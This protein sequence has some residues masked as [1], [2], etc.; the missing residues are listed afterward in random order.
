MGP[1]R[2]TSS[3]ERRR[4]DI[5]SVLRDIEAAQEEAARGFRPDLLAASAGAADRSSSVA[6]PTD[7]GT[8]GAADGGP[9]LAPESVRLDRDV[10]E[11]LL[12]G[13]LGILM[14]W[15]GDAGHNEAIGRMHLSEEQPALFLA[16]AIRGGGALHE[17]AK[18]HDIDGDIFALAVRYAL[19]PFLGACARE[20]K[21]GGRFDP[22]SLGVGPAGGRCPVCGAAPFMA[23]LEEEDGRKRLLCGFCGTRWRFP[24]LKCPFCRS[25]DQAKLGHLEVEGLEGYRAYVCDA[26]RGYVKAVDRRVVSPAPSP[27]LADAL[28]PELDEAALERGYCTVPTSC[29]TTDARCSGS[30]DGALG[31]RQDGAAE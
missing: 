21:R 20:L 7:V 12:R 22:E 15:T 2:P 23:E 3:D 14:R 17:R 24:R 16:D 4:A 31:E 11:R 19:R 25:E 29:D 10:F 8:Q 26:C 1:D 5:E 18:I 13:I 6:C 27:E 30:A 9:L 28:T